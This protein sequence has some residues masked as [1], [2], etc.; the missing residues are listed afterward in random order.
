MLTAQD[1]EGSRIEGFEAG[2]DN[3]V[4]KPL[5]VNE[6]LCRIRAILRRS[7]EEEL[8]EARQMRVW[9]P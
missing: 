2:A 4:T 1:Q 5:S 3:D 9:L 7:G 8:D 6:L